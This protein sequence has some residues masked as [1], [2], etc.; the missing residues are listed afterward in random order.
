MSWARRVLAVF[1]HETPAQAALD[2][3]APKHR[4]TLDKADRVI[5]AYKDLEGVL[6]LSIKKVR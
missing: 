1:R 3:S 4:R 5:R 6:A 2:A